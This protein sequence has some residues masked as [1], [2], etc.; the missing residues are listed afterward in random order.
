[1]AFRDLL[2]LLPCQSLENLSL[3]REASEAEGLLAA[4]TALYHPALLAQAPGGPRWASADAPPEV[5]AESL[6]IVPTC[7]EASLPEGWIDRAASS[8]AEVVHG[9][10]SREAILTAALEKL[11]EAAPGRS[12]PLVNDFLALGFAH[13]EVELLTRQL[14]YMSNLDADRFARHLRD[15]VESLLADNPP[16]AQEHL[17]SAFDRLME[18]REYF[19]PVETHLIDLTLVA[20]TTLGESLRRELGSDHPINLLISGS[21]IDRMAQEHPRSLSLLRQ[22][23]AEGRVTLVG[24]EYEELELPLLSLEDLARQFQRGLETYER[25]L[26]HRPRI[27]GRRRFGLSPGLPQ[28]LKRFGFTGALHFTLDEGRFPT[29]SQSKIRWEGIDGTEIEALA[30]V[31]LPVDRPDE[32]LRLA[33]G[34]GSALDSDPGACT[35]FAHWPAQTSPWFEDLRCVGR[36]GPVLGRFV[37]LADY[38][39]QAAYAGQSVRHE[40]DAYRS[41]YLRQD[42]ASSR[43]DPISR[44]VRY[45][46]DAVVQ[47]DLQTARTLVG[48]IQG[49]GADGP[50]SASAE[51]VPLPRADQPCAQQP[52]AEQ[53]RTEQ[54]GAEQPIAEK[55]CAEQ[56][57]AEQPG[58][59]S[60]P[61][62]AELPRQCQQTVSE[63]AA[64][65]AGSRQHEATGRL[66]LNLRSHAVRWPVELSRVDIAPDVVRPV[67]AAAAWEG[68]GQV[69][70]EAP[71]MGFAWVGP[72]Q[73]GELPSKTPRKA[74]P[75]PPDEAPLA[76]ENL[77][78]NEYLQVRV[79]PTTGA[80]QSIQSYALRGNRL[81]EQIAMRLPPPGCDEIVEPEAEENYSLMAADEMEAMMQG[82]MVGRLITR[83]RLMDREGNPV[84]RFVQNLTVRRGSPILEI[85]IELEIS[86]PPEPDPWNSYYAVRFAWTDESADVLRGVG[87]CSQATSGRVL[88]TPY[89]V[90]IRSARTRF[91]I[92]PAG[93]PYHRRFGLRKLDT[94]LVVQGET[95][96][97]FHLEI[98]VDL[99]HPAH[100]ALDA[101]AGHGVW[102]VPSPAPRPPWGWLFHLDARNV[103]ATAWNLLVSEG[104]TVG[105]RVRLLETEGRH[106]ELGLRSFRAVA[107]AKKLDF[108]GAPVADLAVEGDEI[109]LPLGPREWTQLEARFPE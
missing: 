98:G 20:E 1:M 2:V 14:R 13:L 97:R 65:I 53:P 73:S 18:A 24:G 96:R 104:K 78:H 7:A 11:P 48:L 102:L 66:L 37:G 68:G 55:S 107:S 90:D 74:R 47:S 46:H 87:L 34:L 76:H 6:V 30:R 100:A 94:L 23:L 103:V 52:G 86:R 15:A 58:A 59:A 93:L 91:T 36:Y 85:D 38:F 4:W 88:E 12:S 99:K 75:K 40:A 81:A 63:L 60:L 44:W 35:V 95:A 50:A 31:P 43:P 27:F 108:L 22:R 64:R 92:L 10:A 21:A 61:N 16:L 106:V 45:H 28:V 77:L 101:M 54:L 3:D 84:A 105:F 89:Y 17:R 79:H 71:A 26:G 8:G 109:Q 33:S 19:F 49:T 69:L 67:L 56:P 9:V 51:G 70:V 42:V 72:G 62:G 83:G 41:P 5:S 39:Q 57:G 29:S 82:P 32:F 80:I 25:F